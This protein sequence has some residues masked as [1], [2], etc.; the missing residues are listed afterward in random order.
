MVI[1]ENIFKHKQRRLFLRFLSIIIT[2]QKTVAVGEGIS[3]LGCS[4]VFI[5][6]SKSLIWRQI[7]ETTKSLMS[8][9]KFN[10]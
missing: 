5:E 3:V 8:T 6:F 9:R 10:A 7:A 1:A 2:K 4:L